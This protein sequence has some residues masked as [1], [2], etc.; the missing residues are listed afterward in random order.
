MGM[1][2]Q[3]QR[4]IDAVDDS[5]AS[6]SRI[7]KRHILV[8]SEGIEPREPSLRI[9]RLMNEVLPAFRGSGSLPA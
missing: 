7:E 1:L 5:G 8:V 2:R 4:F 3:R 9:L 6:A